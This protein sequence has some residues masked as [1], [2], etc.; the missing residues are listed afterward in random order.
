MEHMTSS[1]YPSTSRTG[2]SRSIPTIASSEALL[3]SLLLPPS[4]PLTVAWLAIAWSLSSVHLSSLTSD[5]V[6]CRQQ[7][8]SI[9]PGSDCTPCI[10]DATGATSAMPSSTCC[11]R[12]MWCP[13]WNASTTAS[14]R[15]SIR[16]RYSIPHNPCSLIIPVPLHT[17]CTKW[18]HHLLLVFLLSSREPALAHLPM[19]TCHHLVQAWPAPIRIISHPPHKWLFGRSGGPLR[20]KFPG[21]CHG[22]TPGARKCIRGGV[23]TS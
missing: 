9:Q 6:R 15:N 21:L 12:G 20:L 8:G 14:G 13:S 22:F 1:T 11:S 23:G 17:S 3:V 19:L 7:C 18:A 16:K 2:G 5:H 4:F 10:C